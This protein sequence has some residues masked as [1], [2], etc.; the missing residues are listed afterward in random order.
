MN[1]KKLRRGISGIA[2]PLLFGV[3]LVILWQTQ[4]LHMWIGTDTITLPLPTRIGEIISDNFA[5]ISGHIRIT[6]IVA[7]GGLAVGSVLG[8]AIALVATVFSKWAD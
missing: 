8:Y 6:V 7:L 4:V 2:L 5:A 1:G 3:L